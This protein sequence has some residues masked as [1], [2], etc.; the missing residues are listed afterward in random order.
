MTAS[1][2]FWKWAD[3]D[4]PGPPDEVHAALL[5]GQMHPAIQPFDPAKLVKQFEKDATRGR[6]KGEEWD[7]QI[8]WDQEPHLAK[9]VF[10]TL[11]DPPSEGAEEAK[12]AHRYLRKLVF[13]W[14]GEDTRE[15]PGSLPKQSI[16]IPGDGSHSVWDPSVTELSGL[17][18]DLAPSGEAGHAMLMNH[19]N[20]YIQVSAL[21]GRFTVE[22]READYMKSWN[23]F[24][25]WHVRYKS[26]HT[27]KGRAIQRRFVPKGMPIVRLYMG[28][29]FYRWTQRH[30]FELICQ[31]DV[32]ALL[33][34]FVLREPR[35]PFFEWVSLTEE[36]KHRPAECMPWDEDF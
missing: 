30:E 10:V 19:K 26:P 15:F 23:A 7:W 6:K 11:P 36:M 35:P 31:S 32:L 24:D 20:D 2:Y 4:L 29:Y 33:R 1:Y 22:W 17:L 9:F 13:G 5:R 3:N 25:H 16:W 34:A 27:M 8:V 14:S 12:M 28:E 21:H 18:N